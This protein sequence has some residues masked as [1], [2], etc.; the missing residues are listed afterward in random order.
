ML[1]LFAIALLGIALATGTAAAQTAPTETNTDTTAPIST[2]PTETNPDTT[3]PT[4][5][6][7]GTTLPSDPGT[8]LTNTGTDPT[9]TTDP[10]TAPPPNPTD[11]AAIALSLGNQKIARSLF[12]AQKVAG[13]VTASALSLDQI[14]AMKS[15]GLG[16]GQIF[17][18]MKEEGLIEDKNLGQVVSKYQHRPKATTPADIPVTDPVL[19]APTP[20]TATSS[21][22][23][24]GGRSHRNTSSG[25]RV[26]G[27]TIAGSNRAGNTQ[28]T[29]LRSGQGH[30]LGR[31]SGSGGASGGGG[32]RGG[33]SGGGRGHGKQ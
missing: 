20:T 24:A 23:S 15:G 13:E 17:K 32:H 25:E 6:D 12:E 22:S 21:L 31:A 14:A 1:R 30:T 19:A 5:T 33:N 26:V 2:A 3:A 18:K 28:G 11:G 7:A 27:S 29:G 8:A 10:G 4:N 9:Q 16:W